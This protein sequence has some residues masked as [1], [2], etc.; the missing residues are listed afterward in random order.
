MKLAGLCLTYGVSIALPGEPP[1]PCAPAP[2]PPLPRSK[3]RCRDGGWRA[4]GVFKNQGDC[5]SFVA[6]GGRNGLTGP[7]R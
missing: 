6:T 5:V 1:P 2:A 3:D 7:P 4:Y